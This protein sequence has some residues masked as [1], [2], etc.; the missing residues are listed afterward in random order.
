LARG[1]QLDAGAGDAPDPVQ[2]VAGV[3][4]PVKGLLL[5]ALAD[6]VQLGPG[7]G[8]DVERVHHR[9]RIG[10]DFGGGDLVAGE[11]VHRDD[12]HRL[13]EVGGL[14]GQP[15]R[16]RGRRSSFDQVEQPGRTGLIVNRGEIDD[17]RDKSCCPEA[18]R[19]PAMLVN[20]DDPHP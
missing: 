19:R 18:P 16:Q 17:Q 9:N 2:R 6:Q 20:T 11:P 14:S 10:D 12:L 5:D 1:E 4:A 3:S 15:R 13:C 8:D 7:Q